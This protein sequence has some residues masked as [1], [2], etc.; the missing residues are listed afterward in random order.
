MPAPCSP[1]SS[2]CSGSLPP[3]TPPGPRQLVAQCFNE[4][5]HK[6]P[7]TSS[8]PHAHPGPGTA[9]LSPP[10]GH[11]AQLFPPRAPA[12]PP[13]GGSPGGVLRREGSSRGKGRLLVSL[14]ELEAGCPPFLLS[15]PHRLSRGDLPQAPLCCRPPPTRGPGSPAGV[16]T[17]HLSS[18][19]AVCPG[20]AI[21][22]EAG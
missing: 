2:L 21:E 3:N 8:G 9:F 7:H 18:S 16:V 6:Q 13:A 1:V 12:S 10:W 5:K 15:F 19:V 11:S 22:D 4:E 14:S 20:R 17:R